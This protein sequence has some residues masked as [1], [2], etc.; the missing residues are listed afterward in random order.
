M[1]RKEECMAYIIVFLFVLIIGGVIVSLI[2]ADARVGI[3]LVVLALG[4]QFSLIV[5]TFVFE[6]INDNYLNGTEVTVQ[7]EIVDSQDNSYSIL[8]SGTAVNP[9]N[10]NLNDCYFSVDTG[11]RKI[12]VAEKGAETGVKDAE[13]YEIHI[14]GSN[15]NIENLNLNDFVITVDKENRWIVLMEKE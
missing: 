12:T 13:P 8:I 1:G 6:K 7:E 2:T 5:D 4:F 11:A 10:I 3:L 15:I 14:N 9:Q